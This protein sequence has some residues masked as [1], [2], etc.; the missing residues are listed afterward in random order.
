MLSAVAESEN[1]GR[2]KDKPEVTE[3][4]HKLNHE[5]LVLAMQMPGGSGR[6]LL[7]KIKR[8]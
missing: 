6:D 5:I 4:L 7:R 2:A 3:L 8:R 1:I